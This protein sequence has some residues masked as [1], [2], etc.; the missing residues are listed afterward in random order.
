MLQFFRKYQKFFFLFITIVIVTTFVFF[1]TYQAIA[2]ALRSKGSQEEEGSYVSQVA[3]FLNTEQW[4]GSRKVFATNFLN[5]GVI[6]KEF[7]ETK[8]D[9]LV[10]QKEG[11]GIFEEREALFL[12]QKQFPPAFLLQVLRYQEQNNPRV[13][14]DPR[15]AKEDIALFGYQSL[16]DWF[17]DELIETLSE[18]I[19]QTAAVARKLGYK[20][21][22]EELLA[23]LVGH[24]QEA[25]QGLKQKIELPV[26]NGY[27]LFRLYLQ[28]IGMNEQKVLQIWEDVTLFRRLMHEVGAAALVDTLAMSQF[29]AYAYENATIELYQMAA[30]LQL[31]S[32]DALK[33]FEAY[34]AAVGSNSLHPLEIPSEYA[35]LAT[36]EAR[37]PE[38]VA[39]RYH[40]GYA[41]VSK[42]ALEAKVSVK[43]TL[44]WQCNPENWK[45]LQKQFPELAQKT[46]T[47]LEVLEK[48]ETKARKLVDTFARKRIVEAHPEWVN[49]ALSS[50]QLEDKVIYL[51]PATP[52]PF[53]GIEKVSSLIT[54]LDAQSELMGYTQDN[55]TY[56]HF[57]VQ[58][59]GESKE[60]LSYKTALAQGILDKLCPKMG[61]DELATKVAACCPKEYQ[62]IPFAYRFA[63]FL[64]A[65]KETPPQGE[66]AKQF[67]IEKKEK[68]ITRS[69][70][71]L[72]ALDEA[73]QLEKGVFSTLKV[74]A[75][76]GAY[77]YR[78]VDR[79]HDKT[80]PL[81]KMVQTQE[82]LSKE[83]RCRYFEQLLDKSLKF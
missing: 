3:R 51:S 24:A 40:L 25:Y 17:G 80:V 44:N 62:Q 27:G 19:V 70:K 76:E 38:L 50:A 65:H 28:Q 23:E 66:L 81:D 36:I 5:E 58:E 57:Q 59:R 61:A 26:Q 33:K 34:L 55:N 2:P 79:K 21:S 68:T 69:E 77:L 4:M 71:S 42:K 35:P 43:E 45:A 29:Y 18:V 22:K 67:V 47:P 16:S 83:A 56:Y 53:E 7:F 75:E 1:G 74:N 12:A 54:A 8:M 52:K 72:I 9:D 13:P 6:S 39:K 49:E 31:R 46:E 63:S 60:V 82:L 73:L 15:L 32:L 14:Q 10:V 41:Q 30:D 11:S 78:L 20:V 37:A 48:M 64:S